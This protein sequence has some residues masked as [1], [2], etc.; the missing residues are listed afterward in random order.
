LAEKA[1]QLGTSLLLKQTLPL[2]Q[3]SI[4]VDYLVKAIL[5]KAWAVAVVIQW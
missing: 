2:V 1:R 3:W 4:A 5:A